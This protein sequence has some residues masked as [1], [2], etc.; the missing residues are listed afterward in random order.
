MPR[1]YDERFVEDVVARLA[2]LPEDVRP[3]WGRMSKRDLIGHLLAALRY[4][5]GEIPSH[6]PFQTGPWRRRFLKT[7]VLTLGFPMKRHVVF[8]DVDGRVL[9][10]PKEEG[11]LEEL[12]RALERARDVELP[13]RP[14]PFFGELRSAEWKR[15]HVKH[16]AHHLRQF[17]APL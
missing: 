6:I 4:S 16:I 8:R 12:R 2:A 14:H 13:S 10:L 1:A 7:L 11:T 17:G 5:L 15:L 3:R 9:P